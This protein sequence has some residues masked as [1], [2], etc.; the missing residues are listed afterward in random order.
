LVFN[1]YTEK[2]RNYFISIKTSVAEN[3]IN[4]PA[5]SENSTIKR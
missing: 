5:E 1:D 4:N 3:L 2:K